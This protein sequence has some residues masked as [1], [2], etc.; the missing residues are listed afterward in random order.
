MKDRIHPNPLMVG[1][2]SHPSL[3]SAAGIG[4][5]ALIELDD[6]VKTFHTP[7]GDVTVLKGISATFY[8][9]EFVSVVGRSGSGKSTLM[10]MITGIDRATSGT[11]RVDDTVLNKMREGQLSVWRGQALGI[12][13]QFFQLLPMLSVIENVMLP[14]DFAEMYSPAAREERAMK[15]LRRV[16]LEEMAFKRPSALSGGQQQSAA[17][18]RALANDPPVIVADEPTGNLDTRTASDVMDLFDELVAQGKTLLMVTHDRILAQRT[19]RVLLLSDGEII[20][21]AVAAA[22]DG[23]SHSEMLKASHLAQSRR[24]EPGEALVGS[25]AYRGA[26]HIIQSGRLET[27]RASE[28]DAAIAAYG[29]GEALDENDLAQSGEALVAR[30]AQGGP[31][32]TLTLDAQARR[33]LDEPPQTEEQ[34]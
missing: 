12:V 26:L 25:G 32:E 19:N 28:P 4:S 7:A 23:L 29:P 9:G 33:Q 17:I 34:P 21:P 5:D 30:C 27:A 24:L 14:M 20:P 16:G 8:R 10:N 31:L 1:S 22:L 13:F 3:K 15:L 6:V 11:V 18:A 2:R